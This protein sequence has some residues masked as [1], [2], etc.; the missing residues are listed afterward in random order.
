MANHL[1]LGPALAF[2]LRYRY[3]PLRKVWLCLKSDRP[4][5]ILTV[6]A[7]KQGYETPSNIFSSWTVKLTIVEDNTAFSRVQYMSFTSKPT[8]QVT[9]IARRGEKAVDSCPVIETLKPDRPAKDLHFEV[10]FQPSGFRFFSPPISNFD[11]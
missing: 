9:R 8:A 1:I 6:R 11:I 10:C 3:L 7:R 5:R 4:I 2:G